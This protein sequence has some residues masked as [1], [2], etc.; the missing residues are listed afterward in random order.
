MIVEHF[1]E[2]GIGRIAC[3]ILHQAGGT[4]RIEQQPQGKI[5]RRPAAGYRVEGQPGEGGESFRACGDTLAAW[6]GK[7]RKSGSGSV[8]VSGERACAGQP[9]DAFALF[10]RRDNGG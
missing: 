6:E 3:V 7:H 1:I 4:L 9:P 10:G 2:P 8:S 5:G